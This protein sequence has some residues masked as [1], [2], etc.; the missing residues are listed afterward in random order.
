MNIVKKFD[1]FKEGLK[2]MIGYASDVKKFIGIADIDAYEDETV[3]YDEIVKNL[4][5][6]IQEDIPSVH[7]YKYPSTLSLSVKSREVGFKSN[8]F[9]NF[10]WRVNRD[11]NDPNK[12]SY[13]FRLGIFI[14]HS[15][16]DINR[17]PAFVKEMMKNGWTLLATREDRQTEQESESKE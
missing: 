16:N 2:E 15:K 13:T 4:L 6:L 17:A 1:G 5:T 14:P 8:C 7:N 10:G 9:I 3:L 11:A 12:N